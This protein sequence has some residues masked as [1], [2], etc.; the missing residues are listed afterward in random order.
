VDVEFIEV[1]RNDAL[2]FGVQL[3]TSFSILPLTTVLHNVPSISS[4]LS[5]ILLG[6]GASLFGI[7]VS[8]AQVIA[9]FT[10]SNSRTLLKTNIRSVDGQPA[11]HVSGQGFGTLTTSEVF[12]N[13]HLR[14]QMKWGERRWGSRAT[15]RRDS[16]LLYYGHGEPGAMSGNWPRSIEFQIQEQDIGDLY[17]IGT[18]ISV[19]VS[20]EKTNLWVY[21]PKGAP[22]M[23]EKNRRCVKMGDAEK[24]KGEWNT[25]DLICFNGDSIHIVNGKV[26]MR[27]HN[28][29]RV[30]GD[31]L[32][33]G[34]RHVVDAG[35]A[36]ESA[37][38]LELVAHLRPVERFALLD[39]LGGQHDAVPAARRPIGIAVAVFRPPGLEELGDRRLERAV[40][41]RVVDLRWRADEEELVAEHLGHRAEDGEILDAG[42]QQHVEPE[43][44][45]V[46]RRGQRGAAQ[47][48]LEDGAGARGIHLLDLH[49]EIGV[50]G[51]VLLDADDDCPATLGPALLSTARAARPDK[52]VT[53]VLPNREFEAWFLASAESIAGQ[54]GFDSS[55]T[56]PVDPDGVRDAKGWLSQRCDHPYK[57]TID[58]APLV[59]LIDLDLAR[60]R[61][62]SFIKLWNDVSS[63]LAR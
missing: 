41:Q 22:R 16:G 56:A 46:L 63:L 18:Q 45:D 3:P 34:R 40:G 54:R 55:I 60:S 32:M 19:N 47:P 38:R 17:P 29:Q 36:L 1:T 59:R 13:Y 12:T 25:L 31:A 35:R 57:P 9:N 51:L 37:D 62:R 15:A 27:L 2:N 24:P 48:D 23:F 42:E 8:D 49:R 21:D 53:V 5:Y 4:G 10:K 52:V 7:G 26:M 58:Q 11:I 61:S 14:L 20:Q 39:R 43:L 33:H 28:A 44:L 6:G 30:D 50:V